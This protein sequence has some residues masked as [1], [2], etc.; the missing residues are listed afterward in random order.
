VLGVHVR[1]IFFVFVID[2]LQLLFR[3]HVFECRG[4]NFRFFCNFIF[5]LI[6]NNVNL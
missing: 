6:S 2:V 3:G 5:I 4:F 1:K